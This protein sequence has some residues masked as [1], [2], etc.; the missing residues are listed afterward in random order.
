[1]GNDE[2]EGL[3]G[4][5]FSTVTEKLYINL[6][7]A[8][9]LKK[10][11]FEKKDMRKVQE[12][13]LAER[14]RVQI[15]AENL[16][17]EIE[18]RCKSLEEKY[19]VNFETMSDFQILD[20]SKNKS[21]EDG[22]NA[23]LQTIT[24]FASLASGDGEIT[25]LLNQAVIK[26]TEVVASKQVFLEKL[27]KVIIERDISDGKLKNVS[28]LKIEIPKFSGYDGKMDFYTFKS[29]F[30]KL[31]EPTTQKQYWADYL[32]RNYLSG[33]ALL[34]VEKETD[35]SKIWERLFQSFGNP[36]ILL[37]NKLSE[38]DKI[39]GLCKMKGNEKI[40]NTIAGLRN[41]MCDLSTLAEEHDIE[42]QLYE[43]GGLEKILFLM[44][45]YRHKKFRS[46]YLGPFSSKKEEWGKLREFL[47][48]ELMLRE[49]LVLDHK[50][51]KM[52]GLSENNP[53]MGKNVTNPSSGIH[54]TSSDNTA[55]HI[56]EK[57][58]DIPLLQL[59][60]EIK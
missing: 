1:M 19:R 21:L 30:K 41:V 20:I 25:K 5:K 48:D 53:G 60:K 58:Q 56:C 35:Y 43:R 33:H 49:K 27:Q 3:Y 6:N 54:V 36:R 45:D 42:G 57:K 52:L 28:G 14:Q 22:F 38:V 31:I 26:R 50:T 44:G 15:Y 40:A 13:E 17:S 16:Y 18:C 12:A 55:C 46:Q 24:S 4:P 9:D 51:A 37:Q 59:Q 7:H 34:L 32:K 8:K 29:Q 39:G 23:I 11:N 10:Q 2:Y 47:N